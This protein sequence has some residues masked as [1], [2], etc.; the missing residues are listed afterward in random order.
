MDLTLI[1][2]ILATNF[3]CALVIG[4]SVA[5]NMTYDQF[6]ANKHP[7]TYLFAWWILS[8]IVSVPAYIIVLIW[9]I[10]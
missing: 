5:N 2:Q 10:A 4:H 1:S 7:W 3:I 8:T 6:M 9:S